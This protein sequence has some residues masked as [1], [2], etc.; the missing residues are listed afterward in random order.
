MAGM[1]DPHI[2][3]LLSLLPH[4][5][6]VATFAVPTPDA[7]R[8]M[9]VTAPHPA[10]PGGL[11]CLEHPDGEAEACWLKLTIEEA[12][13]AHRAGRC[14]AGPHW[15]ALSRIYGAVPLWPAS[16][17]PD[18]VTRSDVS[19]RTVDARDQTHAAANDVSAPADA[20]PAPSAQGVQPAAQDVRPGTRVGQVVAFEDLLEG[21]V[22]YEDN[23]GAFPYGARCSGW[24]W[25]WPRSLHTVGGYGVGVAVIIAEGC[26]TR[27]DVWAA[28]RA[29]EAGRS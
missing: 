27:E 1:L 14:A 16:A 20:D 28:I 8:V 10:N 17:D 13:R 11:V 25:R 9:C 7:W 21:E 6:S 12:A 3:R 22:G 19:G 5:G 4:V 26:K 18:P 2:A 29:H 24:Q 15:S 23:E